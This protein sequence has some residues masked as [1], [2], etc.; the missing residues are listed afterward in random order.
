MAGDKDGVVVVPR[1][2]A[3][4]IAA[5][6]PEQERYEQFVRTEVTNGRSTVGL[7][8]ATD[9]SLSDYTKWNKDQL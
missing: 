5:D 3:N 4:E 9:E 8:P 1:S 7:Y 2:L 6:A